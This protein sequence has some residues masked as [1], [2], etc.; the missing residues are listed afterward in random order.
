MHQLVQITSSCLFLAFISCAAIIDHKTNRLP[1]FLTL[2]AILLGYLF[3]INSN[4]VPLYESALGSLVGYAM[5]RLLHGFQMSRHGF[6]GIG[7]GDAKYL[8]ALA[9]WFGWR[10]I[11]LF[12]AGGALITLVIYPI[13]TNKPFG[14]GLGII[15]ISLF[16]LHYS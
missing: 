16:I 7:L 8:A 11:P 12:L 15:A 9:A 1:D 3:N 6:A 10:S 5:I 2:P 13:R 4:F 14:V